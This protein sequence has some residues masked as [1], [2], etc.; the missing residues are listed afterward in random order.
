MERVLHNY[1]DNS[2]Y[3]LVLEEAQG[4]IFL[5]LDVKKW[6]HKTLKL[7]RED[8]NNLLDRAYDLGHYYLFFF[9]QGGE[10]VKFASLVKE[11]DIE[12]EIDGGVLGGWEVKEI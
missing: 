5:H 6:S 3:K 7:V 8:L 1:A 9:N 2:R 4:M 12:V 11:L 10:Q